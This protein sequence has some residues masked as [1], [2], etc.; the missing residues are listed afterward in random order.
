M[1]ERG[2][3]KEE[4]MVLNVK[5]VVLDIAKTRHFATTRLV[6]VTTNV[7]KVCEKGYYGTECSQKCSP[8]CIDTC[9]HT[10]GSCICSFGWMGINC[11]RECQPGYYGLNCKEEC[12]LHCGFNDTCERYNGSCPRGCQ[13]PFTGTNCL[14][15]TGN[16]TQPKCSILPWILALILSVVLNLCC[17]LIA[18]WKRFRKSSN[19]TSTTAD[20]TDDQSPAHAQYEGGITPSIKRSYQELND[21][22]S[23]ENVTLNL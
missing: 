13:E 14:K 8:K 17:V 2:S 21:N 7:L 11:N 18:V 22:I 20:L 15:V 5:Q 1:G 3:A 10:D 19:Q 16:S 4:G 6:N 23:Y 12:S 9:Q